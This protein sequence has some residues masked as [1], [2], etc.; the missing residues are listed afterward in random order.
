MAGLRE[1]AVNAVARDVILNRNHQ[2][3]ATPDEYASRSSKSPSANKRLGK[4][5]Q[6]HFE[7]GS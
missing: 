5:I 4:S 2:I 7:S 3:K 6:R 1:I